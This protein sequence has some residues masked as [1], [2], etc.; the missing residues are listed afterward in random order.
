MSLN[1]KIE[2][3]CAVAGSTNLPFYPYLFGSMVEEHGIDTLIAAFTKIPNMAGL[4]AFVTNLAIHQTIVKTAPDNW[5]VL[6]GFD[7]C[8]FH[9]I[10]VPGIE[11]AI[12]STFNV[13]PEIV[14]SI[15]N[16]VMKKEFEKAISLQ[17]QFANY[18]VAVQ[19]GPFLPIGR[20][21]LQKRGFKMG[22]PRLPLCPPSK[23]IILEIEQKLKQ[24]NFNLQT[25]GM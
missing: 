1:D 10:C 12:G 20:Y 19:R 23:Q 11:G 9:A 6:H 2:N 5:E 21:F 16:C 18:W 13:V 24:Y 15:Y 3:L 25:G 7:Q 17:N 14:T 4:K 8:L 22:E